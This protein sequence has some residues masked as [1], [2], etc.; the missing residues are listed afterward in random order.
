MAPEAPRSLHW[1]VLRK[2]TRHIGAFE[3]INKALLKQRTRMAALAAMTGGKVQMEAATQADVR[4]CF[5]TVALMS[6]LWNSL[7]CVSCSAE[8]PLLTEPDL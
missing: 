6:E 3:V 7:D 4:R 1:H 2:W 5:Q 8:A